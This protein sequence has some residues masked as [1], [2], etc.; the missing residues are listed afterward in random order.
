MSPEPH[1]RDGVVVAPRT[2]T[3]IASVP[4]VVDVWRC[5]PPDRPA[6][7]AQALIELPHGATELRDY[8]RLAAR[9]RSRLPDDLGAFFCV[10]TDVGSPEVGAALAARLAEPARY[11]L[12]RS[13]LAVLVVR[14]RLPRT[15]VDCNRVAE[16][17][18]GTGLTGRIPDYVDDAADRTLLD[19]LHGQYCEVA[20]RAWDEVIAAGGHGVSLHSYAPRSVPIERVTHEIVAQLRAHWAQPELLPLRPEVDLIHT[21]GD[22]AL[23]ADPAWVA[24]TTAAFGAAGYQVG[25]SA[26]YKLHPAAFA[27]AIAW[28][29]PSQALTIELRRDLL[30]APWDPFVEMTISADKAARAAQAIAMSWPTR[31][32]HGPPPA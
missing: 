2:W 1:P 21:D 15:L 10:N 31:P 23:R 19:V 6:I 4:G 25:Q 7:P 26:S 16:P 13:G 5:A 30:A 22:G 29:A 28:R 24:A 27:G 18:S 8:A 3:P 32:Q 12:A 17:G 20:T 14:S 9:M 11:D